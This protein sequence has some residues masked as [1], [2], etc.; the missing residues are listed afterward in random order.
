M[1]ASNAFRSKALSIGLILALGVI[2]PTID[3]ADNKKASRER[4][5]LRRAQQQL[6]L[7]QQEK[8][9]LAQRESTLT[10]ELEDAKQ[11][12]GALGATVEK[13]EARSQS[14]I[15]EA[16][17]LRK[18][19]ASVSA[20]RD[21]IRQRLTDAEAKI[22]ATAAAHAQSDAQLKLAQRSAEQLKHDGEQ[23]AQAIQSCENKNRKL[24]QLNVELVNRF[25]NRTA[26]DALL[27][28]E[29][30]TQLKRVEIE[31]LLEEY[32]DKVDAERVVK[33]RGS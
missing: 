23:K 1:R 11:R 8:S 28:A 2:A 17:R 10:A 9:A 4:E 5:A 3:A 15:A 18:E 31:N 20:D 12:A 27:E 24:Y 30:F 25:N 19:L 16:A 26:F 22:A 6:Q 7:L 32:R 33:E 21:A 14:S 13:A 29:P